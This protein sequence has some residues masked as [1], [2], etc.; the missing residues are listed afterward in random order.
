MMP[1]LSVQESVKFALA[2]FRQT[3]Q[4]S[5]HE[6]KEMFTDEQLTILP[7]VLISPTYFA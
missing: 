7:D 5:W 6:H 3:H 1:F 2:V 4:D